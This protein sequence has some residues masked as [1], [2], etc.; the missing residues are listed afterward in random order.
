[1]SKMSTAELVERFLRL[2]DT[3]DFEGVLEICAPNATVWHNDG[4][5]E[6]PMA[7]SAQRMKQFSEHMQS[8][9]YGAIRTFVNGDEA[10]QQHVLCIVAKDNTVK[11]VHAAMYFRFANG[12]LE[13]VEEYAMMLPP[14]VQG[15]PPVSAE[16]VNEVS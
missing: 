5:G 11:E 12:L 10:L 8:M 15:A 9:R 1:M 4:N 3:F 14:Q 7:V 16:R 13:R 6:E 2:V